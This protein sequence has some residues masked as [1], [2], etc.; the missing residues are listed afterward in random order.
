MRVWKVCAYHSII[1]LTV[2]RSCIT[3]IWFWTDGWWWLVSTFVNFFIMFPNCYKVREIVLLPELSE[4]LLLP[5]LFIIN[6]LYISSVTWMCVFKWV[7]T[8]EFLLPL[9]C[10]FMLLTCSRVVSMVALVCTLWTEKRKHCAVITKM[11][12]P[13]L[14]WD[15]L[16]VTPHFLKMK[17]SPL[18]DVTPEIITRLLPSYLTSKCRAQVTMP[19]ATKEWWFSDIA[20]H[21]GYNWWYVFQMQDGAIVITILH[22]SCEL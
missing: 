16:L 2:S 11:M 6:E 19:V 1:P 14:V 4:I 21:F 7:L 13:F 17:V 5:E 18:K 20:F 8:V 15:D 9:C 12:F 22:I 3:I 10:F